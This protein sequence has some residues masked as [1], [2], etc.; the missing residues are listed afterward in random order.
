MLSL[1][2]VRRSP[3]PLPWPWATQSLGNVIVDALLLRWH[4]VAIVQRCRPMGLNFYYWKNFVTS[5]NV[6]TSTA[7]PIVPIFSRIMLLEREYPSVTSR[8]SNLTWVLFQQVR[9]NAFRATSK[10]SV[11]IKPFFYFISKS[12]CKIVM[13][14]PREIHSPNL[15][16]SCFNLSLFFIRT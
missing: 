13:C 3:F 4:L 1:C 9:P 12:N 15:D 16:P 2:S 14:K 7:L 5:C 6:Q 10:C 8:P 11:A